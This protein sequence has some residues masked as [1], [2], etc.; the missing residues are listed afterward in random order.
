M[1]TVNMRADALMSAAENLLELRQLDGVLDL[2]SR[3]ERSGADPDRCAAARWIAAMLQGDFESAWSESDAIRGRGIPDEHRMWQGEDITGRRVIV[4]CLHGFGD[5]VQFLR[6]AP[7]L[8]RRAAKVIWEMSPAMIDVARCFHGVEQ[9]CAWGAESVASRRWDVQIEVM[10]LP[11]L[12]RTTVADL[13]IAS[14]YLRL[15]DATIG[16]VANEMD[17]GERPRVGVVWGAGTWNESRSIPFHLLHPLLEMGECE[18]WNLQGGPR[19][20]E[21]ESTTPVRDTAACNDGILCLA[22]VISQL[23]LVLTVDTLAAHLAGALGVPAWLMLQHAADWRW[24]ASRTESPWYP[25]LRIFRQPSPGA[26]DH[27]VRAVA[28]RLQTW[29]QQKQKRSA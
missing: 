18:F 13:P 2:L 11:Y 26:W 1:A 8:N 22:G 6:Y 19:R 29:V 3:A 10:E 17:P 14:R 21:V 9:V 16:R 27:V 5:T 15:P 28:E 7:L 12:F 25:S 4:R 23:D 20:A 24:M